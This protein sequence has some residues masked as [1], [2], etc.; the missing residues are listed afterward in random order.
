M[1][2]IGSPAFTISAVSLVV[3]AAIL[4]TVWSI[5]YSDTSLLRSAT[6]DHE[7]ISPNADGD[8][9][10]TEIRYALNNSALLSIYFIDSAGHR[11]DFRESETRGAGNYQVLFSGIVDGYVLDGEQIAGDVISRLLIDGQYEWVVEA[12]GDMGQSEKIS[13]TLVIEDAD[14]ELPEM[15]NFTMDKKLFSPNQDGI[16]DRTQIQLFLPKEVASLR[17]ALVDHEG[18][19]RIIDELPKGTLPGQPGRH[20]FDYEGGVDRKVSPPPDGTYQVFAVA[21]DAEGQKIIIWDELTIEFGGVPRAEIISPPTGD[22]VAFSAGTVAICETLQF[23]VTLENYGEAPIR[24]S[25]PPPGTVYDSDWNFNTLG[26]NTESGAWRIALGFEDEMYNYP[27]RWALGAVEELEQIGDHYYLMPGRRSVVSGAVRLVGPLGVRNP[28]P[29][30]AGLIHE[31]VEIAVVN[32]RVDPHRIGI[33]ID[34][35]SSAT[36]C[37]ARDP[38]RLS[39]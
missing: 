30:W 9:D 23:T 12:V 11:F 19:E 34:T 10:L 36:I 35:S 39:R 26:W 24:T 29:M 5:F 20:Y 32:N 33:D 31:D 17:V 3:A 2:R 38:G 4:F 6:F 7:L 27:Y 8:V 16:N 15:R 28:Q 18:Y 25:G 21:E 14:P 1:R 13:G 22:T 37:E